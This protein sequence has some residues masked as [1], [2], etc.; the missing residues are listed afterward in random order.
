[1]SR[2]VTIDGEDY[3]LPTGSE[4]NWHA[5]FNELL[6]ALI[7]AANEA[8]ERPQG[9]AILSFG[10]AAIPAVESTY[11]LLPWGNLASV[12]GSAISM[13]IPQA[14]VLSNFRIRTDGGAAHDAGLAFLLSKAGGAAVEL[15]LPA[16][17]QTASDTVSTLSVAAGDRIQCEVGWTDVPSEPAVRPILSFVFTPS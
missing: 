8:V 4:R 1:M 14:G 15:T 10:A 11:Y 12:E 9:I 5:S 7:D 6:L 2:T 3:T 16:A 13:L 17:T